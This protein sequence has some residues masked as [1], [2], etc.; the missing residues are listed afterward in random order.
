MKLWQQNMR[1]SF[2][3]FSFEFLSIWQLVVNTN[4]NVLHLDLLTPISWFFFLLR[5]QLICHF[6]LLVRLKNLYIIYWFKCIL[7]VFLCLVCSKGGMV[8]LWFLIMWIFYSLTM[9]LSLNF[10]FQWGLDFTV[11]YQGWSSIKLI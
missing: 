10:L 6:H 7:G 5:L 8:I 2:C 4:C 3:K 9:T 11:M 1:N